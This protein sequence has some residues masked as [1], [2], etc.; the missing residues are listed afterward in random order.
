M[1]ESDENSTSKSI[2]NTENWLYCN[3]DFN[4]PNVSEPDWEADD[5]SDFEQ[6]NVINDPETP[7]QHDGC[8]TPNV[9]GLIRLSPRLKKKAEMLIVT[10][11]PMEMRRNKGNQKKQDSMGQ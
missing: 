9:P 7:P 8:A 6:D 3:S 4:N 10:V 5:E 11:S 2:S 1:A